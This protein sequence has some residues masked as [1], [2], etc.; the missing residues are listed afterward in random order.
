MSNPIYTNL[1]LLPG[2]SFIAT[3]KFS[4]CIEYLSLP[5]WIRNY[6][7]L[8]SEH[9]VGSYH[10]GIYYAVLSPRVLCKYN[11]LVTDCNGIFMLILHRY[12]D[13]HSKISTEFNNRIETAT[14]FSI[15]PHYLSYKPNKWTKYKWCR[16]SSIIH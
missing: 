3:I 7:S 10:K 1:Y 13:I 9:V 15:I 12:V 6:S 2:S 16:S 8:H 14:E 11:I 4:D 5:K